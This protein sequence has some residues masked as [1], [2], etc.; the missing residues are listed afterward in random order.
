M[1]D[2]KVDEPLTREEL[3]VFKKFVG[4][5]NWLVANTRSDLAI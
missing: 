3:K 4:K 5:L 2:I 1:R